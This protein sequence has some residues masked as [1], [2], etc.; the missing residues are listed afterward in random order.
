MRHDPNL[1]MAGR[2]ISTTLGALGAVRVMRTGG[3]MGE[4]VGG[5]ASICIE[6]DCLPRDVYQQ[7]L[8]LLQR[9]FQGEPAR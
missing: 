9:R 6:Q 1:F 8:P 3:L 2:N 5:A 7:H 4:V